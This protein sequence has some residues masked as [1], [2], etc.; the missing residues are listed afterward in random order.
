MVKEWKLAPPSVIR[1]DSIVVEEG[2]YSPLSHMRLASLYPIVEGY[3]V[4]T[5]PGLRMTLQ[6]ELGVYAVNATAS[7]TPQSGL[8]A[9]ERFHGLLEV[10]LWQLHLE[11]SYNPGDFYDL[12]GPL[13]TSRKGYA[14]GISYKDYLLYDRPATLQ[15]TLA[16]NG[17]WGLEVLPEYQNVATTYDKFARVSGSLRYSYQTRSLG[18]V[19]YEQGVTW[20]LSLPAT[21][22]RDHAIPRMAGTLVVGFPALWDLVSGIET[23]HLQT[24]FLVGLKTIFSITRKSEGTGRSRRFP[25]L[26]STNS[27]EGPS[28]RGWW[29]GPFRQSDLRGSGSQTSTV[30]G[31]GSRFSGGVV[32][33]LDDLDLRERAVNLGIQLDLRIVLFSNLGSTLSFG[34]AVA[35]VPGRSPSREGMIS[36]RIL[37]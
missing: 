22:V 14:A 35:G 13:R 25:A 2:E 9:S 5:A 28:S 1:Y 10:D 6:D 21:F 26:K 27:G 24:S 12:F 18:A 37:G 36:L 17:Y 15:W 34:Y 4:Y 11:G 29:S 23:N 7:I 30:T 19:D 8:P 31:P 32:T 20:S 3:K 16:A 33:N